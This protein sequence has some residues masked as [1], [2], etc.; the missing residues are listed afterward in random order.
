MGKWWFR[1]SNDKTLLLIV[2]SVTGLVRCRTCSYVLQMHAFALIYLIVRFCCYSEQ[3]QKFVIVFIVLILTMGIEITMS[4]YRSAK[5]A[6]AFPASQEVQRVCDPPELLVGRNVWGWEQ[7]N[8]SGVITWSAS[9]PSSPLRYPH[10]TGSLVGLTQHLQ[11]ITPL[12][13]GPR[14]GWRGVGGS[15]GNPAAWWRSPEGAACSLPRAVTAACPGKCQMGRRSW[16]DFFCVPL[17]LLWWL[18][19]QLVGCGCCCH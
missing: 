18:N 3:Q 12:A 4:S 6:R 19:H 11:P 2:G 16:Q 17:M 8:C 14:V 1:T 5:T 13:A 9:R 10:T 15:P 7:I